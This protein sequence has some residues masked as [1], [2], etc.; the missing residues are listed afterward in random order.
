MRNPRVLW[1]LTLVL[2]PVYFTRSHAIS[3]THSVLYTYEILH[4]NRT[5]CMYNCSAVLIIPCP[6]RSTMLLG[7]NTSSET[8]TMV[9]VW[10]RMVS[11]KSCDR[12]L[13]MEWGSSLSCCQPSLVRSFHR[14]YLSST[15]PTS[16]SVLDQVMCF[17]KK[18]RNKTLPEF[19]MSLQASCELWRTKGWISAQFK[20]RSC[21]VA[22]FII[23]AHYLVQNWAWGGRSW[24]ELSSHTTSNLLKGQANLII[25]T[26]FHCR[27]ARPV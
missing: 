2:V 20:L 4:Y 23:K 11:V 18:R 3:I 5:V 22:T 16:S 27:P 21:F 13:T 14:A 19:K 6:Y 17:Y 1:Q 12:S 7:M 15:A 8:S 9:A 24:T 25:I 26:D 10:V